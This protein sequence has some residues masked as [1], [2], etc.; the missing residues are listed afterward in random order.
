MQSRYFFQGQFYNLYIYLLIIYVILY[1]MY[2]FVYLHLESTLVLCCGSQFLQVEWDFFPFPSDSLLPRLGCMRLRC[3]AFSCHQ[4]SN[5]G[6]L[7]DC[8]ANLSFC[9]I[10][11]F[12]KMVGFPLNHGFSYE[13]W[14]WLGVWNGGTTIK[15]TPICVCCFEGLMIRSWFPKMPSGARSFNWFVLEF[16]ASDQAEMDFPKRIKIYPSSW[17]VNAKKMCS[18]KV[19]W[20]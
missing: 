18:N 1:I 19:K 9:F 5:F 4:L 10:W 8:S 17:N 12:P 11:L 13:K 7:N 14:S 20:G 2:I 16:V 3:E 15:E 6:T